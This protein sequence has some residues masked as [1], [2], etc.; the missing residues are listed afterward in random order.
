MTQEPLSSCLGFATYKK[1]VEKLKSVKAASLFCIKNEY[2]FPIKEWIL[3]RDSP[4][5]LLKGPK[6][7]SKSVFQ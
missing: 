6:H 1:Q 5:E 4:K 3:P 7:Q 2:G